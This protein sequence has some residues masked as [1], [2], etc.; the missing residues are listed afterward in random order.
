MIKV[1]VAVIDITP[2]SGLAMAGFAARDKRAIAYHDPLTVRAL[3]VGETAL[4]T[5]DVI[6]IDSDLSRRARR[7]C[8]LRDEAVSITAIHTHSGP[9]SMPNRLSNDLDSSFIELLEQAIVDAVSAANTNK[10]PAQLFGGVG[11]E[12]GYAK[13]RRHENGFIDTGIPTLFFEDKKGKTIAILVSYACH[14][15]VLGADNLLWT[16]DYVHFVRKEIELEWP[17]AVAIFATG[18]AGDINSGHSVQSSMSLKYNANRTF[19]IAQS[20]GKKI[21]DS[22]RSLKKQPLT[23][24]H[25]FAE[26]FVKL[27]FSLTESIDPLELAKMWRK[28]ANKEV[29]K[30]LILNIWA[31]WAENIMSKA[32]DPLTVRLLALYWGGAV[33]V[34]L[35]GEI[36]AETAL[37]I[38]Q[39]I[40]AGYPVFVLAYSDDNPGYIPPQ[41]EYQYGGYEIEEAHRFYGLGAAFAPGSA[42]CLERAGLLVSE[43]AEYLATLSNSLD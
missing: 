21:A 11:A 18:C 8:I 4:V 6:G 9:V 17:G 38:R 26:S 30:K 12:P 1:G 15:V 19:A 42:E 20:I 36:F 43:N 33:L 3:V 32:V 28:Q 7:R 2:P 31:N 10:I 22:V 16:S 24:D 29:D 37:N 41:S 23:T 13:N 39:K 25:G 40:K 14:P 35:P 27:E 34:T 5:T